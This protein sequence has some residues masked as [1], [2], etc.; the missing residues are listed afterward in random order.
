MARSPRL[1]RFVAP[2]RDRCALWRLVL[3]SALI[4]AIYALWIAAVLL[5]LW[6]LGG[7]PAGLLAA[8]ATPS[9]PGPTLILFLTFVGMAGAPMIVAR[10]LH[11]RRAASLFG[12][13][14]RVLRDFVVAA[15]LVLGLYALG[16]AAW[17]MGY[18]SLPGLAPRLW[19]ALLPLTMLGLL[20]QTGAEEVL[21][22]GYLLQQ[23]A[24]R[25]RSPL[26]WAVLP[27]IL[28][29]F[30]H[31]APD[32]AG[33]GAWIT[34]AAAVAFGLA[35]AD[36]TAVTGSLGAAWGFHFANNAVAIAGLATQGTI[37]GL[38]FRLTPYEFGDPALAG[39]TA[40]ADVALLLL[41]WWV[42]RSVLR[43]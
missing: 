26:I 15:G 5:A 34:V 17:G 20:V 37:T 19:L 12:P 7:D 25:F 13:A 28:F 24:A 23:F 14:P 41:A 39:W 16:L 31:Y 29:G 10:L 11:R 9:A 1:E 36:L 6:W 43:R 27:S 40:V 33:G 30:L 8:V 2:A 18:D 42:C 32:I 3:G 38:A 35:V 22:R 4:V 21:F